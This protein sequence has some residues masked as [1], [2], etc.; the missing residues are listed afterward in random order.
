MHFCSIFLTTG[1][2]D[3]AKSKR[4]TCVL[5]YS[6]ALHCAFTINILS[7]GVVAYAVI[8]NQMSPSFFL[9][10]AKFVHC[11]SDISIMT[12]DSISQRFDFNT[13]FQRVLAC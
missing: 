12:T 1:F 7:R 4:V 6:G 11:S 5:L 8:C 13:A 9:L 10:K 2:K 3:F